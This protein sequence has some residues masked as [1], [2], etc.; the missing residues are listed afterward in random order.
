MLTQHPDVFYSGRTANAL[1][2]HWQTLRMYHL[3][4]DQTL[5]PLPT[6]SKPVLTFND[7]EDLIQDSELSEPPDEALDRELRLQQRRNVREIRQLENEVSNFNAHMF[8][9]L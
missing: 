2:R 4:P 1:Y 6:A 5:A 3:L 7:A 9:D 8:G